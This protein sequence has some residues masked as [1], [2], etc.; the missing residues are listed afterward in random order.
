MK[1]NIKNQNISDGKAI[2]E[3]LKTENI[4]HVFGLI[5]SA[6]IELFDVFYEA[7]NI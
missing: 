7:K 6:T 2:I 5:S 1:L 4:S 3:F